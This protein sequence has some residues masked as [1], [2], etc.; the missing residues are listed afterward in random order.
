MAYRFLS[1]V[2]FVALLIGVNCARL[3]QNPRTGSQKN[4]DPCVRRVD[5]QLISAA[6]RNNAD[7]MEAA[8]K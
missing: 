4:G 7:E 1:C 5:V 8:V 6:L 3:T 2:L